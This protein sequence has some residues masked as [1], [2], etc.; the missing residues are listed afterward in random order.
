M[1]KTAALAAAL[2]V[3][4]LAAPMSASGEGDDHHDHDHH[5]SSLEG[6]SVVHAWARAAEQGGDTNV[7]FELHNEGEEDHLAGAE[8]AIAASATL[9]G[10]TLKDGE[11]D[12]VEFDEVEIEHGDTLFDPYGMSVRLTGLTKTLAK[13]EEFS[14][15]LNFE[16]AGPLE[17]HVEVEAANA[18]QHSHAGH[19]H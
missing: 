10:H 4:F 14:L 9:V 1:R 15:T 12:Y 2:V 5:V 6:L 8:T 11:T 18:D 19:S 3:G 17:I 7:Y 13:G 16:H